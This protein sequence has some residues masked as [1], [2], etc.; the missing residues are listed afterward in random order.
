MNTRALAV[1]TSVNCIANVP[2]GPEEKHSDDGLL[3]YEAA[4]AYLAVTPRHVR[5]LWEKRRL[6]AIKVGRSVRFSRED[7]DAFIVSNRVRA[8]R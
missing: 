7:L 2:T 4:A 3:D 5:E 1:G 8:V 6:G